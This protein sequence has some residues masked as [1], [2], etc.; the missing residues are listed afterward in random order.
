MTIHAFCRWARYLCFLLFVLMGCQNVNEFEPTEQVV[1]LH[2]LGRSGSAMY[3]LGK[4][5][6]EAGYQTHIIEYDSLK[7][8]PDLIIK[9]VGQEI[10]ERCRDN[11]LT[12]HFV[13]HSLGGLI[14]RAYLDQK[15][16]NHLGRV[17]LLGTPNQG[18]ELV[19]K[20]GEEWLLRITGPTVRELGTDEDSFPNRI[21]APYYPIGIIAGTS[22][23]NPLTSRSLPG[24][25]DGLVSV[26]S[27][28]LE[29]MTDFIEVD[30]SHSRLRYNET[31]AR[32]VV[33]FLKHGRFS[34]STAATVP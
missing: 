32:E 17:V 19:D 15:P 24:P 2:G 33:Y 16:I 3:L 18:S 8:S 28:K 5:I 31:A 22:S 14:I 26:E 30:T 7:K 13:G 6:N 12:V 34:Y 29:G 25:D 21:G 23:S 20:F 11:G 10:D 9:A 1:L 4:R 27:T